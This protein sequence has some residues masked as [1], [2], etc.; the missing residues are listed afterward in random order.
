M[1]AGDDH[2]H[3]V[4]AGRVD[5]GHRPYREFLLVK[6]LSLLLLL[7]LKQLVV[8]LMHTFDIL[9]PMFYVMQIPLR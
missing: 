2:F 3:S 6:L 8:L 5:H 9:L 1:D 7:L 4:A